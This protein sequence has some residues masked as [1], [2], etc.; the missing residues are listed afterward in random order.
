MFKNGK[1]D[2]EKHLEKTIKMYT[3]NADQLIPNYFDAQFVAN[4]ILRHYREFK[5][6]GGEEIKRTWKDPDLISPLYKQQQKLHAEPIP[7]KYERIDYKTGN[8]VEIYTFRTKTFGGWIVSE[9]TYFLNGH[10]STSMCFVPDETHSWVV[11]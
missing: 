3:E 6:R 5:E 1:D 2:F 11:E 4:N 8:D 7:L 9:E 10:I